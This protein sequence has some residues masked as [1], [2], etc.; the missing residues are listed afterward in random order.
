MDMTDITQLHCQ[1][2]IT[3][4]LHPRLCVFAYEY[5]VFIGRVTNPSAKPPFLEEQ[6]VSLILASLLRPVRLGRSYQEH[7]VPAGIARKVIEARET[8]HHDKVETIG[9]EKTLLC[10]LLY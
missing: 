1:F 6:F 2:Y 10:L 5:N 4:Q 7:K 3:C 8:S 9:G